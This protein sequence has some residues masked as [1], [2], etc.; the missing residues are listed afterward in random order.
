MSPTGL[1]SKASDHNYTRILFNGIFSM[2]LA[3]KML[4]RSC[5]SCQNCLFLALSKVKFAFSRGFDNCFI[6]LVT[7]TDF[8]AAQHF[9]NHGL[10]G[11]SLEAH[12]ET[13]KLNNDNKEDLL[14]PLL[15]LFFVACAWFVFTFENRSWLPALGQ[16]ADWTLNPTINYTPIEILGLPVAF[17]ATIEILVLGFTAAYLLLGSEQDTSIKIISTVGLGFG[18]TGLVTIILGIFGALYQLPL[19]TIILA[20]SGFTSALIYWRKRK[21]KLSLKQWL[22]PHL[23]IKNFVLPSNIKLWLPACAAIGLIFFFTFYH[24]LLTVIVHWDATVYH[25]VMAVFM[26]NEHAIPVIAGPSIG[27]EMSAN[28]PPLF[29]SLGAYY[30]IQIGAIQD[31]FLRII[32]PVMG[33]LTVL[34]T[35][36]IGE[37]IADK[38]LGLV[39]AL[40]LAITPMFFRYA[41]YATSY[42]ILT[43]FCT[44]SILFLLFAVNKDNTKYWLASGLFY[45][46]ALLTS[47]VAIYLAPFLLIALIAFL[48][49]RKNDFKLN[50]KRAMLLVLPAAI[51]GG[52]WYARNL[53][54]VGNPI[55][56][57]AY[58]VLGGINIDPLIMQT[59]MNGIKVSA[60]TSFFGAANASILDKLMIFLNYRTLFPSISLLSVLALALLPTLKN[61]SYWIIA[62]WP[63]TLTVLVLSGISW[64]F[65][66]HMVFA[67]PGFALLSSLPIFKVLEI[68]KKYDANHSKNAL[69]KIMNHLPSIRKTSI[70]RLGLVITLFVA[71]IFPSF[72]LSMA[73]KVNADNLA[74]TVPDNYLWYLENPNGDI[75]LALNQSYAET[76]AWQWL[77]DHLTEGDKVATVENR[78]YYIRNCSNEYIFYLDGWE[79]RELYNIT[80]P[81]DMVQF[82]RN[83]N[84]LYV[85][86]VYWARLHGHFDILPMTNFLGSPSPY[87]PTIMDYA[88]NP[89]IY[90]VGPFESPITDNSSLA[91]SISQQGWSEVQSIDGVDV[92]SVIAKNDSAKLYVATPS[93]TILNITYL[94]FGRDI[95]SINARNPYSGDWLNG[96]AVIQKTDSGKWKS[97][98]FLPPLSD[99]GF[100]ELGIHAYNENF[101]IRSINAT[102][103]QAQGITLANSTNVK[104][105]NTT[106]PP[107]L[108]V[109]LP[110]LNV[111]RN[112]TVRTNTYGKAVCLELYEGVIQ[113]WEITDWWLHHNLV[114]R[115]PD[116][117]MYGEVNPSL[118]WTTER[119]G[120]YTLV[121]VLRDQYQA[122][123]KIDVQ[124]SRGEPNK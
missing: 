45:G 101:T 42:S 16:V 58:T 71:F 61:K 88:L 123:A 122:D 19:N 59:T 86:D 18:L 53:V 41:I 94:D 119:S 82:L 75:W 106:I 52:V 57:S 109:H 78:I 15:I 116:T 46:F 7:I 72:T 124:L 117:L 8:T 114:V 69:I 20:C 67:L 118:V 108:T 74:Q 56:P 50:F 97:Y 90:H 96:Y 28:F 34:V 47:Y 5:V 17:L 95:V 89:N 64:G 85:L 87:F 38:K 60:E 55:Y 43:F 37:I 33:L 113:P 110:M 105:T 70:I 104:M 100:V 112:V 24:A 39:A 6:P 73:G 1:G 103:Y 9:G 83:Q 81:T 36:K 120:P 102:P 29:S 44:A 51:I 107:T 14:V 27:I 3:N 98:Q 63:L 93:L 84:V 121:I 2:S 92:Q 26:Y 80:D 35:Y 68:C 115:S 48:V 4:L 49:N 111:S 91:V 13:E 76:V 66:R 23:S 11:V 65:P 10:W 77:N 22:T 40:L 21:E 99:K 12:G 32:S 62:L 30:Y 31:I 54:L 25:A 79:A